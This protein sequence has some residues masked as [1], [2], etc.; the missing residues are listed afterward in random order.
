MADQDPFIDALQV[1]KEALST[2]WALKVFINSFDVR[3]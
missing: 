1:L 2:R 3:E